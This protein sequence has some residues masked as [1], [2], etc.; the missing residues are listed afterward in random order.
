[1]TKQK[2][3]KNIFLIGFMGTGKSTVARNLCEQHGFKIIEMD[4]TIEE[5]E[6][7]SVS[8]IFSKK[9]ESYFRQLETN[10][11]IETQTQQGLVISCGGG[12]PLREQNVIEM[13]KNGMVFL[14]TAKPETIYDRV[15]DCHNRPLLENNMTVSFIAK[16]MEKRREK[17]EA[18][19]DYVIYVDHKSVEE[20]C[21]EILSQINE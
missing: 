1:M 20:I 3:S 10:L 12:V 13:K 18:C 7:M 21:E 4:E 9:G 5:R 11:L 14:L 19:A 16:L 17:Y 6:G 8:E 2:L 15:K